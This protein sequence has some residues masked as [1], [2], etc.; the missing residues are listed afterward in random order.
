MREGGLRGEQRKLAWAELGRARLALDRPAGAFA[1]FSAGEH[2]EDAAYVAE[3]VLKLEELVRVVDEASARVGDADA[4]EAGPGSASARGLLARRLVRENQGARALPYLSESERERLAAYLEDVRVGFDSER[5]AK[6]RAEALWRAARLMR[7]DGASLVGSNLDPY[8]SAWDKE[9]A[10][11]S[12]VKLRLE[13]PLLE[14]GIFAPTAEEQAR[15]RANPAP[16]KGRHHRYRAAEL[17]WWAA[18]LMPD[19]TEETARVLWEAGGWLKARDPKAAEPFYRAM[20]LRCGKTTLG[21]EAARL[22]WFPREAD[23]S[24]A[25]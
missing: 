11:D 18:S 3:R 6:E 16:E 23:G 25:E 1:A 8:W 14:G 19:Q 24:P 15:L 10:F 13:V 20:V 7:D 17:A 2:H 22:R 5:L 4:N 9:F 21:R 12:A